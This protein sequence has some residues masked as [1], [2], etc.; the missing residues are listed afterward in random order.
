[1]FRLEKTP[2]RLTAVLEGDLQETLKEWYF[3]GC[4]TVGTRIKGG[5]KGGRLGTKRKKVIFRT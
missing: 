5:W 3:K 4:H 1:M 2:G